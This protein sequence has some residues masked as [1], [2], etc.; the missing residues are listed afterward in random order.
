MSNGGLVLIAG[1]SWFAASVGSPPPIRP[2]GGP[3]A[4]ATSSV[5]A[6]EAWGAQKGEGTGCQKSVTADAII[7]EAFFVTEATRALAV[8]VAASISS[9]MMPPTSGMMLDQSIQLLPSTASS[10]SLAL[11]GRGS[12]HADEAV[13]LSGS[14]RCCAKPG[15]IRSS[16][17]ESRLGLLR[18]A[19]PSATGGEHASRARRSESSHPTLAFALRQNAC[20]NGLVHRRAHFK[21]TRNGGRS[22]CA[23]SAATR[24]GNLLRSA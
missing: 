3:R 14:R 22:H 23:Y 20:S 21:P 19:A 18:N 7:P 24:K 12:P 6:A 17:M 9:A 10:S 4:A 11:A 8:S 13:A 5:S 2:P 1:S 16:T 15:N